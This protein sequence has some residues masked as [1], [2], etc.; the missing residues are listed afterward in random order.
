MDGP[1]AFGALT[2]YSR[3]VDPFSEDE[4]RLLTELSDDLASGIVT[5]RSAAARAKA[6]QE[7]GITAEELSRSNKDLEMFAYAASHD[8]Q[9]PLRAVAGFMGI[10]KKQYENKLD[11]EGLEYIEYAVDGAERMQ[12][13]IHDLLTYSRVG[14]RGAAF[15]P[16]SAREA[17]DAAL[18]N[19]RLSIEECGAV[20]T[21]D[22]LPVITADRTQMTQV[23]QNLIGNA[24][25]FRGERTPA[26]AVS[27]RH[28]NGSW[29]F[30]IE[31]NGIGIEPQ[32][33]DRIFIIFQRLHSREQYDGTGIGLSVVKKI[34]ERHAGRI[35]VESTYGKGSTFYFSIPNRGAMNEYPEFAT[36]SNTAG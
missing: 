5:I 10:L 21:C 35:W 9:E 28:E 30:S 24:L 8:L 17:L 7:L 18:Y 23:F 26:I 11:A 16:S 22:P 15:K 20:V 27:S 1:K 25:K 2:I 3:E 4:I 31:D 14:T 36:D 32:Y 19:L 33:F 34:I 12:R 29:I 13:L 6:E